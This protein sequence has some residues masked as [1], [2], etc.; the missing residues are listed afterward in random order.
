MLSIQSCLLAIL[1]E[2]T[3]QSGQEFTMADKPCYLPYPQPSMLS[4]L[5]V[6]SWQQILS[7]R[8]WFLSPA[9]QRQTVTGNRYYQNRQT[10]RHGE[11][12]K[13]WYWRQNKNRRKGTNVRR[14]DPST[15]YHRE[16]RDQWW[17]L[18]TDLKTNKKTRIEKTAH[19]V[20]SSP[21]AWGPEFESL[22]HKKPSTEVAPISG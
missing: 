8:S 4:F 12:M 7:T 19:W 20:K 2:C 17:W 6:K 16:G 3:N 10:N 9:L 5:A 22:A 14:L 13:R 21:Q 1:F 11:S 18:Q 15:L